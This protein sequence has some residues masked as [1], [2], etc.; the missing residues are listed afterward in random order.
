MAKASSSIADYYSSLYIDG[1]PNWENTKQ[2]LKELKTIS[3]AKSIPV[4]ALLI[5]ELKGLDSQGPFPPIYKKI[6][7]TFGTIGILMVNHFDS[8]QKTYGENSI[9]ARV[10]QDDSH[11]STPVHNILADELFNFL[12]YKKF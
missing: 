6:E 11:P 4:Y 3:N 1:L 7:T 12:K 10:A 9:Q 8:I 5:P 2:A